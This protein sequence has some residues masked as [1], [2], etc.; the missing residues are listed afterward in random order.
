MPYIIG[1]KS[2]KIITPY[3]KSVFSSDA[4]LLFAAMLLLA[5]CTRPASG[6]HGRFLRGRSVNEYYISVPSPVPD[7][8]RMAWGR[9]MCSFMCNLILCL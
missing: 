1:R 5:V 2:F 9:G 3:K 7:S 6:R 4:E 8:E